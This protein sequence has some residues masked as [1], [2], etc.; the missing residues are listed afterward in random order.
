MT[1]NELPHNVESKVK[2]VT[3][4]ATKTKKALQKAHG[5]VTL[6]TGSIRGLLAENVRV[7]HKMYSQKYKLE[8]ASVTDLDNISVRIEQTMEQVVDFMNNS[9]RWIHL[10]IDLL[11]SREVAIAR[12]LGEDHE[13]P[14]LM[15]LLHQ[16]TCQNIVGAIARYLR[17]S[18]DELVVEDEK[19]L[20]AEA[21]DQP[22][23]E[24]VE[25][26][27]TEET[28]D[29]EEPEDVE[30]SVADPAED[31][32][33][34]VADPAEGQTPAV[35]EAA[36]RQ[37]NP[38][39]E[40]QQDPDAEDQPQ[41]DP[42]ADDQLQQGLEAAVVHPVMAVNYNRVAIDA[43][44]DVYRS[45]GHTGTAAIL[46]NPPC[47]VKTVFYTMVSEIAAQL[48]QFYTRLEFELLLKVTNS[49]AAL[50]TNTQMHL[51]HTYVKT[52]RLTHILYTCSS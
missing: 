17:M 19:M 43:V 42:G 12:D 49:N 35:S 39:D 23:Q 50:A 13:S 21:E 47:T 7:A 44:M 9:R 4:V 11:I 26:E 27:P 5:L 33:M 51:M 48:G 32:E 2:R 25:M 40:S 30:M 45:I 22:Q 16:T 10:T 20:S 46:P 31:V 37:Q 36:S 14:V 3:S 24:D 8:G 52:E 34:S 29:H 1:D 15:A 41:Q 18:W 38:E 6:E 28:E